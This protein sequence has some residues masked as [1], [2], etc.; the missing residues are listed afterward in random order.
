[1]SIEAADIRITR[2]L[3][4]REEIYAG[5]RRAIIEGTFPPGTKMTTTELAER[6]GVSRT[7][8]REAILKL[9]Q[10]GLVEVSDT[11]VATVSTITPRDLRDFLEIRV[12][13]EE[14]AAR[15]A[16]VRPDRDALEEA[17]GLLGPIRDAFAD[18]DVAGMVRFNVRFHDAILRASGNPR[19]ASLLGE[20]TEVTMRDQTV[21]YYG[22][23]QR[24][25]PISEHEE[26][27]E[28]IEAADA[29]RAA[30]IARRHVERTAE[31][32]L[33]PSIWPR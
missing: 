8:V 12:V 14:F 25:V 22:S 31:W 15:R 18:D 2:G 16:A 9:A 30:G 27:V 19:L 26:L 1:M 33:P 10:D 17:K 20:L 32:L 23:T 29:D 4:V 21:S 28:A 5:L 6:L 11:G 24:E 3:P 7:P 13:L